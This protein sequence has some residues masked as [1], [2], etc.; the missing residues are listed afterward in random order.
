[1]KSSTS[2]HQAPQFMYDET[3]APKAPVDIRTSI[4]AQLSLEALPKPGTLE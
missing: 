3:V 1:M 4:L 2:S